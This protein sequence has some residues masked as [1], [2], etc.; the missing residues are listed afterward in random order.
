MLVLAKAPVPG[1]VKTRLGTRVGP[2]AAAEVAAAALLDTLRACVDAVGPGHC[3][4]ALA[5]DLR[6]AVRGEELARALAGWTVRAQRGAGFAARLA[7]AHHDLGPGRVVQIGMDTPQVTPDLLLGVARDPG[8][9]DAVLGPAED[10]GWWALA[11]EEP[12]HAAALVG[13]EMSTPRTHEHTRRALQ[14]RGLRVGGTATL[15]DVDTA[16]D[17]D[18][19]AAELA[20]GVAAGRAGGHFV[21]AWDAVRE[22]AS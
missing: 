3:H 8:E 19:V 14:D 10:G 22:D 2:V 5:G 4:L 11:L 9:H 17:A 20:A 7:N 21:R 18:A 15:R 6:Q 1:W 16:E 13:V 12:R